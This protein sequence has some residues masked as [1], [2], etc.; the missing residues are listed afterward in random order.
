[1][2]RRFM[3][4]VNRIKISLA[5]RGFFGTVRMCWVSVLPGAWR[6]EA[7]RR[8]IDAEFDQRYGVDTGGT[9]RPDRDEVVGENWSFGT[10]YAAVEPSAFVEALNR[11][12]ICHSDFIFMD[13]G[14]GKGRSLLLA[15]EFPFKK[16]VGV[17]FCPELNRVARQN[18]LRHPTAA[19]RNGDIEILD[20][21]ATKVTIPDEPLVLFLNNPFAAPLMA[22]VVKNVADSF[23]RCPRRIVV[24]YSWP[25]HA[26]LW[27]AAGFLNRVHS[28]PAIFDT[29]PDTVSQ[30]IPRD[31]RTNRVPA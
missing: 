10:H 19:R 29:G 2:Q 14:S 3:D 15:S 6:R 7:R 21:D 24:I 22:T 4:L 5:Q 26:D 8:R 16:I 20:A 25:F 31:K 12:P 18:V 1:M 9:L 13:F 30:P 17:E 11:I 28:S 27:E 23:R